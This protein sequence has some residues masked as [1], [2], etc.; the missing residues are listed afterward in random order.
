[1]RTFEIR[2]IGVVKSPLKHQ[3]ESPIQP[4]YSDI[5]GEIEIFP[6][7]EDG[8]KD[9]DGFSHITVLF[10]FDR[11]EGYELQTYPY[12][13]DEKRGVFATRSPYR[14]N[15]IGV[16]VL[17]LLGINGRSIRVSGLDIL[18][19]SPVVDIKPFVPGFIEDAT[20][21]KRGWLESYSETTDGIKSRRDKELER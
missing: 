18:D 1:M 16:S 10:V 13:G 12:L 3:S 11:S 20:S 8:L 4:K 15:R 7:F 9:L 6:E 2:P 5:R 17:K 21:V 14:P 19:E